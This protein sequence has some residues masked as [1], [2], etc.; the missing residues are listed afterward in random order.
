M[1]ISVV[2]VFKSLTEIS[3]ILQRNL[4]CSISI[5]LQTVSSST[6]E[7]AGE[8]GRECGERYIWGEGERHGG[9]R[10]SG[11]RER[12]RKGKGERGERGRETGGERVGRERVGEREYEERER[13]S[14]VTERERERGTVERECG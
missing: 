6:G 3:P 10:E 13:E 12:G 14:G 5:V 7:K 2:I 9:D 1:H 8:R 11:V 4:G